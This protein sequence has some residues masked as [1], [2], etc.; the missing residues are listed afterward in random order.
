M[1]TVP[2]AATEAAGGEAAKAALPEADATNE[3]NQQANTLI[4]R[5]PN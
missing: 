2:A 5:Q 4:N 3:T 1:D